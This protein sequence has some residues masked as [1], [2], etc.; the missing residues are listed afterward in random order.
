MDEVLDRTLGISSY[1]VLDAK[2]ELNGQMANQL[3]KSTDLKRFFARYGSLAGTY[4][5]KDH[6]VLD[7]DNVVHSLWEEYSTCSVFLREAYSKGL[8]PLDQQT[9]ASLDESMRKQRVWMGVVALEDSYLRNVWQAW[10]HAYYFHHMWYVHKYAGIGGL[11]QEA[12]EDAHKEVNK[13]VAVFSTAG[14]RVAKAEDWLRIVGGYNIDLLTLMWDERLRNG[15]HIDIYKCTCAQQ[16]KRCLA[17]IQ[18]DPVK[19]LELG[20]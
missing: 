16:P 12:I 20:F 14:T 13:D 9:L 6:P 2:P 1:N 15:V 5:D 8:E 4:T 19:L 11:T 18:R 10:V 3:L 17:C 7:T